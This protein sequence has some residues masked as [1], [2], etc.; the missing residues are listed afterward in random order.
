MGVGHIG[1]IT[2]LAWTLGTIVQCQCIFHIE[3]HAN[4][5][6]FG[7]RRTERIAAMRL[8]WNYRGAAPW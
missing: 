7:A 6:A 1:A 2:A 4:A 3:A 8:G 5:R